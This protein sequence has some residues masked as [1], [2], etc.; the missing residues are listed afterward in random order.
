MALLLLAVWLILWGL[1]AL[2]VIAVSNTF[3]GVLALIAGILLVLES[4]HPVAVPW[5]RNV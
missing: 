2:A 4:Y 3:L 1:N 5:R